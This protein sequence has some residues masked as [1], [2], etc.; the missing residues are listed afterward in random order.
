M[1]LQATKAATFAI[2]LPSAPHG[3]MPVPAGTGFFVSADGLFVTARHVVCDPSSGAL[4]SDIGTA[5]LH[6]ETR[7]ITSPP[8]LCQW[9]ELVFDDSA[10]DIAVLK[11]DLG[12]NRTKAWLADR[13]EFPSL[14]V[15][16]DAL[17]EA[18]PVYAFGYPLG[19]A[20]VE[21]QQD[22]IV[23][24]TT[25]RPRTT[26]AIVA[27]TLEADNPVRRPDDPITYVLDKALNYGNSGGP[28]IA[29]GT[30]RVHAV[31]TRF[32]PVAVPQA[33]L[34]TDVYVQV[35]SL[36]GVVSAL[37]NPAVLAFLRDNG[38]RIAGDA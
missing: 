30:G 1:T 31:C 13:E 11:V 34:G 27:S 9:P 8:I 23:G 32:Q 20:T 7:D 25:L 28:I 18:E 36:Y 5:W 22:A 29:T 35:P 12:R 33:H 16:S 15:G 10:S 21:R 26:S 6:K 38:A 2:L 3:G 24:T 19:G 14:L 37:S 17:D 4:R